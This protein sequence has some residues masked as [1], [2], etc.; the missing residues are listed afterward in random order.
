MYIGEGE[1]QDVLLVVPEATNSLRTAVNEACLNS[2]KRSQLI[3]FRYRA[4]DRL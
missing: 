1:H 3:V 2:L 4:K